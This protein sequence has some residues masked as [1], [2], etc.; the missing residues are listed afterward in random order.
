MF[1]EA[2]FFFSF[3]ERVSETFLRPCPHYCI[4]FL[5]I[6]TGQRAHASQVY[7]ERKTLNGDIPEV[8]QTWQG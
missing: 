2:I 8:T 7:L 6:I 1:T 5:D 4:F 3:R